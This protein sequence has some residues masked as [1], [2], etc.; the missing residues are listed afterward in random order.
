[1]SKQ[2]VLD[3]LPWVEK[4]RPKNLDEIM[5][6]T[7]VVQ[8]LRNAIEN[9]NVQHLLF[10]GPSGCGKTSCI[11]ACAKELYGSKVDLM[12]LNINA[13]EDRGI[14]VIRTRIQPFVMT[15]NIFSDENVFKLVIL[16][17]VD[18]MTADAQAML[19]KVIENY[20]GTTRF[21][22]ICNMIKKITPALQS[23]C[24]RYRF[25]PLKPDAIRYKLLEIAELEDINVTEDGISTIQKICAGDMRRAINILQ[26]T[27]LTYNPINSNAVIKCTGYINQTHVDEIINSLFNDSF[28]NANDFIISMKKQFAYSLSDIITEISYKLTNDIMNNP[29]TNERIMKILKIIESLAEIEYNLTNCVDESIQTSAVV[30]AFNIAKK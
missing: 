1:M 23:R 14:E 13:S 17:E 26:S 20:A 27:S 8:A 16:D 2:D 6:H 22:L 21:C 15:K 29:N 28:V 7:N 18:A 9:N 4:Y 10:H 24:V 3:S 30:A 11:M 5:S 19:R 12:V 25:S